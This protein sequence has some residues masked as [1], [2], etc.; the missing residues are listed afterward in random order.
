MS[1]FTQQDSIRLLTEKLNQEVNERFP[2]EVNGF[3][4]DFERDAQGNAVSLELPY[5]TQNF[6]EAIKAEREAHIEDKSISAKVV[7]KLKITKDGEQVEGTRKLTVCRVPLVSQRGTYIINGNETVFVNRTRL[8]NGIYINQK[9]SLD[10]GEVIKAN[11]RLGRKRLDVVLNET[12]MTMRIEKFK[13]KGK[14]MKIDALVLAGILGATPSDIEEAIGDADILKELRANAKEDEI[15][16]VA[17]VRK[18]YEAIF[19][20]G[21]FT[22]EEKAKQQIQA[23]F[24]SDF[25][26]DDN[27]KKIVKETIQNNSSY[28]DKQALL[29]TIKNVMK[30]FNQPGSNLISEDIRFKKIDTGEDM[31]SEGFGTGL[32]HFVNDYLKKQLKPDT[33]SLEK[34]RFNFVEEH[35]KRSYEDTSYAQYA[36]MPNPLALLQTKY[37][38]TAL[39]NKGV[40]ANYAK[41]FMRDLTDNAFAKIDPVETPQSKGMGLIQHFTKDVVL[42]NNTIFSQFYRVKS[43]VVDTSKVI[44]NIDP[45]DEHDEVIAFHDP[46]QMEQKNGVIRLKGEKVRVRKNGRFD[47]VPVNQVT[48]IDKE[49]DSVFGYATALIPFGAHNDGARMLMGANMQSQAMSLLDAQVPI[50]QNVDDNGETMEKKVADKASFTLK[51]AHDGIVQEITNDE[52]KIKTPSGKVETITK[53]N[54]FPT[55][56]MGGYINHKPV[57]KVGDSVK[58]GQVIA[59]GWQSKDGELALGTNALVAYMPYE[60]YNFEDGVVISESFAKRMTS[61]EVKPLVYEFEDDVIVNNKEALKIFRE[62]SDV[63]NNP[64]IVKKLDA[65]GIIKKG[66][67]IERGDVLVAAVREKTARDKNNISEMLRLKSYKYSDSPSQ[68]A[69]GYQKGRVVDVDV[70]KVGS[71]VRVTLIMVAYKPME[72]GDKLAGR[73]GNKG[74]VTKIEP[75]NKMP[76]TKDNEVIDLIYSPLAIPS[77][78]NIGQLLEVNAGLVAMKQK[79]PH[80]HVK[81]FDP[82][83]RERVMNDLKKLGIDDGKLE[84]LDPATGYAKTY[85]NKVTVGPMYI[86]KLKHKVENKITRRNATGKIDPMTNMPKKQSGSID[87][88]RSNPQGIGAMEFWSLTS[89]GAVQNVHEMNTLKSDGAGDQKARLNIFHAL[90]SGTELPNPMTPETLKALDVQLKGVGIDIIPLDKDK[91]TT[92]DMEFTKLMLQPLTPGRWKQLVSKEN[93]VTEL[94]KSF[95]SN[96]SDNKTYVDN[97]LFDPKIFGENGDKWGF[98]KLSE[99][100]VNPVF[101]KSSVNPYH[102][103]LGSV[104]ETLTKSSINDIAQGKRFVILDPGETKLQKYDVLAVSEMMKLW[105][106]GLFFDA[107][108]GSNAIYELLK[109]VDL[110]KLHKQSTSDLKTAKTLE[111]KTKA[112]RAF[113]VVSNALDQGLKPTDYMLYELPVL[114]MKYRPATLGK[115]DEKDIVDSLNHLY[116]WNM[117]QEH[118]YKETKEKLVNGFEHLN[119]KQKGAESLLDKHKLKDKKFEI[120]HR[121]IMD[122]DYYAEKEAQKFKSVSQLFGTTEPFVD[123]STKQEWRGILHR[124]QGKGGFIRE[125]MQKKM[126]D[127][128]GRSV[129]VVDPRLDLDEVSLPEDMAAV[130]FDPW[131]QGEL[132]RTTH[133]SH[134]QIRAS[135]QNRDKY[136]RTALE[137]V[138][139][140]HPVI[141]N[142]QPSLHR[143]SVQAFYP[144]INYDDTAKGSR[145]IGL[146]PLVTTG[147]NADFDGDTMAVHVPISAAAKQEAIEKL[148]PSRNLY[149]PTNNG[150][151]MELKHEMQ[152][153]IYYMTRKVPANPKSPRSFKDLNELKK[154]YNKGEVHTYDPVVIMTPKSGGKAYTAGQYMF[155]L[156]LPVIAQDFE[157]NVNID[158]NQLNKL[159]D[160][161]VRHPQG[162]MMRA[163][164]A[165]NNLRNLSFRVSTRSGMSLGVKDFEAVTG[166]TMNKSWAEEAEVV[167]QKKVTEEEEEMQKRFPNYVMN[168]LDKREAFERHKANFIQDKIEGI[169]KDTKNP[170]LGADNPVT[171]MQVSGARA[172]ASQIRSM[173][174]MVG[175]GKKVTGVSTR[176]VFNSHLDG[177]SPNEFWDLSGDSRKGIFDKS[178]ASQD[179]G[180][181]TRRMWMAN[182]QTVISMQDCGEKTGIILHLP[183]DKYGL[184][185]RVLLKPVMLSNGKT[186]NPEKRPMTA[187]E[188][189]E[190]IKYSGQQS[191][192]VTVRSPLMCKAPTGICQMCYGARAGDPLGRLVPIGEPV[193]SIAAQAVGE[194]SQQAIMRTFHT[195][196]ASSSF[197][198]FKRIEDI[199]T[200]PEKPKAHL[201]AVLCTV[202]G[203]ITSITDRGLQKI[204]KVRENATNKEIEF[205]VARERFDNT[206][207]VN[208]PIFKGDSLTI[209]RQGMVNVTFKDP[210]EVLK[211][212]GTDAAKQYL[213]NEL[214]HAL[215]MGDMSDNDPRHSEV[216]IANIANSAVVSNGV[217]TPFRTGQTVSQK[218]LD[219]YNQQF[220]KKMR[221]PI[222]LE[223]TF[224]NKTNIVGATSAQTYHYKNSTKT[225]LKENEVITEEVFDRLMQA[226]AK[227]NPGDLRQLR[228]IK[229]YPEKVSYDPK[230]VG[231]SGTPQQLIQSPNWL[232]AASFQNVR[233][234]LTTGASYGSVD[235]LDNPLSRQ[236][237]GK[238]QN[239]LEEYEPWA[240][241]HAP[242]RDFL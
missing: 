84:L 164:E 34:F 163:T 238:K 225:L 233:T 179:P 121:L 7:G 150:L 124:F 26:Y 141:L 8:A 200:V 1:L 106:Q 74:I 92:M 4:V 199:L 54:F 48:L 234:A 75:D 218:V 196:G 232:T 202:D 240:K 226:V 125:K 46:R 217:G 166:L 198:A 58:V 45:M 101:F 197:N 146:N 206:L 42:K 213:L 111:Q 12:K 35:V 18:L 23:Y 193:G 235:T 224:A 40:Q 88:E 56:K 242:Y 98:V 11:V 37:K 44:D 236:M 16:T 174:G 175:V 139:K 14:E 51:S 104:S 237:T 138:I 85:E 78:K 105:D 126:Q 204:V 6:G 72:V 102:V 132:E 137:K 99:P 110:A 107:D 55:G 43:G 173:A 188:S 100:L 214:N 140:D 59:D 159:I 39:G 27:V 80:Y 68:R 161:I 157:K 221:K 147:F 66:E 10:A 228:K 155:N 201:K 211:L 176:A 21:K 20:S 231:L 114:P 28:F 70:R 95:Q 143:H 209:L 171:I 172:K 127:Y 203:V 223:L 215:K 136:F 184:R 118:T 222:E 169:L 81:S 187:L 53:L 22:T 77:R 165:L 61:E 19:G 120:A 216:L 64:Q 103:F 116:Q 38:V 170:I 162:G 82:N 83:E 47:E 181:L 186:I 144:K 73:H 76:R 97:G 71:K 190:I 145:T 62:I 117:V 109:D 160:F 89:A 79:N 113:R 130:I 205:E 133:L 239:T 108:T 207:K 194:P 17:S 112:E 189:D 93:E 178:I 96:R 36:D 29:D 119:L 41:E 2:M 129:I 69:E 212:Q 230:L 86:M 154:A 24:Q 13:P 131:V 57:V 195:G 168:F 227:T 60:G 210:R 177:L 122:P 50:V 9:E 208:E 15:D 90:R 182:K 156:S 219:R 52:F 134:K 63:N 31:V 33:K 123:R 91:P 5:N 3:M 192:T 151:I 167:A 153:G 241:A 148:M 152:L 149:N 185:G 94:R 25:S 158:K 49:R 115:K 220:N 135:I 30:E 65:N 32:E 142:R 183:A 229:I 67:Y 128:S 191:L 87:G 180:Y